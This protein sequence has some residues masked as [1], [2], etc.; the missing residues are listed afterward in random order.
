MLSLPLFPAA[1]FV[2]RKLPC[3]MLIFNLAQQNLH[4]HTACAMGGH[5]TQ[6]RTQKVSN[7]SQVGKP[8]IDCLRN[9]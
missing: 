5:W 9:Q 6:E 1:A 3:M 8:M 4:L 2:Q 7:L